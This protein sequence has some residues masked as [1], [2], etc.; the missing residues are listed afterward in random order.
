MEKDLKRMMIEAA[1]RKALRDI[2][3][4]P[5]R[6][7]RNLVELGFDFSKGS[8]Q[9]Q[10]LGTVQRM[11]QDE[12]SKYYDLVRDVVSH[13]DHDILTGFGMN[14]GY[15]SCIRGAQLIRSIEQKEHFNIPWSLSLTLPD[16]SCQDVLSVCERTLEQGRELGIYTYLFHARQDP[17]QLFPLLQK[18]RDCAFLLFLRPQ[19]L[20]S[21]FLSRF[22]GIR[23]TLISVEADSAGQ[24]TRACDRLRRAKLLYTVHRHYSDADQ[25]A[26][27]DDSWLTS[28]LPCHPA[29][30][31]L[32]PGPDCSTQVREAVYQHV[33]QL[34]NSQLYPILLAEGY[35]D[36]LAID[37]IISDDACIFGFDQNGALQ[38]YAGTL[39]ADRFNLSVH[40]L[41][42]I[43][44][45]A[46]PKKGI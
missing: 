45:L 31:I 44:S 33:I 15:N 25:A 2:S 40:S 19:Q 20:T 42:H 7:L 41:R 23:N 30:A 9:K 38:T 34:R 10:L 24:L 35:R 28:L 22:S 1:L 21:A 43:F 36:S 13:T 6:S 3:S 27:L 18:Y 37:Q 12:N 14:L 8:F 16:S 5:K 46:A 39:P 17:Q 32:F 29:F 26:L 11:L 4:S